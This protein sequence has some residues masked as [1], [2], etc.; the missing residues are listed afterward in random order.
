MFPFSLRFKLYELYRDP[1]P[2]IRDI[3]SIYKIEFHLYLFHFLFIARTRQ[4]FLFSYW[5]AYWLLHRC[6]FWLLAYICHAK[7]VFIMANLSNQDIDTL[8][9]WRIR[10]V[11][12]FS[13][14]QTIVK[15]NIY[16]RILICIRI[17][18]TYY[19]SVSFLQCF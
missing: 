1:S 2:L 12:S 9:W 10:T 15:N 8:S 14:R 3:T 19:N 11:W 7:V 16:H 5:G 6:S 18:E 17:I 13:R 4:F